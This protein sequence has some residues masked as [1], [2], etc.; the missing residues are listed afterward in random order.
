MDYTVWQLII[1]MISFG[2]V[3]LSVL[4]IIFPQ[5]LILGMPHLVNSKLARYSD[6]VIRMFLGISL[7]LSAEAALIPLIFTIFG[8]L[9]MAAAL[10]IPVLGTSKV[11]FIIKYITALL[12]VWT[13]RLVCAF[14][15]FLFVFLIYNIG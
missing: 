15:V 10:A 9:S 14:S 11:E 1:V 8:Y 3:L 12:P 7:V 5:K 2:M 13:V 4:C 6:I